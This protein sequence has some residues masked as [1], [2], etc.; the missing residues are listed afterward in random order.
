MANDDFDV[1]VLGSG[2]TGLTAAFTAAREGARTI[3]FEKGPR[4]GGTSAWSGGHVWVPGNPH[5]P[6]AGATDDPEEAVAYLMALGR[7]LVDER[8]IRAFVKHG[9]A[10]V[11]Y[12]EEGGAVEFYAVP[13]L[14]D[15]H[16]EHP[17]GKPD[18][19]RTMG[20]PLFDFNRL[21][22]WRDLVEVT[23]YYSPHLR[24]DETGIG[25]VDPQPPTAAELERRATAD[26]RAQGG[27]L[28]GMLI[29]GCQQAGVTMQL[30]SPAVDLIM[31][32]G[33]VKGVL[34]DEPEGR[35]AVRAHRGVILATGGFEWSLELRR[36]FLRGPIQQ[37]A[38][39]PSN[40]GDG[41]RLAMKVGAALQNMRE[42]W[43]IPITLLPRGI[44]DMNLAMVNA[45]RTR[46]RG[47]MV[48]RRGHRFVN[49]AANYN[50]MG[51]AFH[52]E[53]V[54]AFDYANIPSWIVF[55]HG[56]LVRYG[57]LGRPYEG[58]VPPWLVSA[59]TI[60]ELADR[61]G[62]PAD[63]LEGTVERWN[64]HVAA[65]VDP[66]FQRGESAH[67]RWWGD[68]H[69]KG[70]VEGTLGPIDEPPY[71]AM[72]LLPGTIGTKGGPLTDEHARVIDLD[73]AVIPGLYAAGNTSSPLGPGYP[74]P[75]GTL[76]PN[77]TYGWIA[78]CHAAG[79]NT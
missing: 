16:P 44:N 68:P 59:P 60:A 54:S 63:A 34:V 15:Y 75:G 53:D 19:G 49:E 21:G 7:G 46:P 50:A 30:N 36:A 76:G 32:R 55:D 33:A 20:T 70:T 64:T 35:R 1:V 10:M 26:E 66:D 23:P 47:I 72:E 71:Y 42:A 37:P 79:R 52:Q 2:A 14:P 51:G 31:E 27:G 17:G 4:L 22:P 18:G 38:S 13:H 56:A 69:R 6:D 77:M 73:G 78:A 39:I 43:W 24:I 3:V 48:N 40:T 28:V 8:L 58:A 61:L 65:G 74:G 9:P 45:D 67:D 5:M 11:T 25:A 12:L 29:N 57:S 62:I 41:L